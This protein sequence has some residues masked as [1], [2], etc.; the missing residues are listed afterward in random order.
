M[1]TQ[2]LLFS[3]IPVIA[4]LA[5]SAVA[6]IRTPSSNLRSLIL[7]FAAGVVFSVVAVELI[8]D[9]VKTHAPVPL[10]IGFVAGF[11][12]MIVLRKLGEKQEDKENVEKS[13]IPVSLVTAISVDILID[14]LLL[15]TGFAA[16]FKEGVLLSIALSLELLSLG[17]ATT[18]EL[19]EN[20][21]SRRQN[22]TLMTALGC[23]FIISISLGASILSH[24]PEQG[25]EI[26]LSFG[27]AALLFLVTE[28]LLTEAH[29]EKETVWHTSA[30]FAGF[31][32]F[33]VFGMIG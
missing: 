18:T 2:V 16:G 14:G 9:V 12:L 23:L 3:L 29:E 25:L 30:F 20:N 5:G 33:V 4:M 22:V 8:P 10:I 7:H 6:I 32:L 21:V 27:L 31:L 11:I 15:G 13:S 26:L 17:M 1:L 19:K 24:L 28:E